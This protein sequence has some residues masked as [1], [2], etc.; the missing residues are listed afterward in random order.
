MVLTSAVAVLCSCGVAGATGPTKPGHDMVPKPFAVTEM[1]ICPQNRRETS[2]IT[3]NSANLHT[4]P[5]VS[6]ILGGL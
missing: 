5:P 6:P 1:K 3:K 4:I 2:T